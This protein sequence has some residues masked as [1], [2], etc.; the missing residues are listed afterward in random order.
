MNLRR[1]RARRAGAVAFLIGLE[2]CLF[3][4]P[5]DRAYRLPNGSMTRGGEP[6]W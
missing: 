1:C 2:E 4:G 3:A 5:C 6:S